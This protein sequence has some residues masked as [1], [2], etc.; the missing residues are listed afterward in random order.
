MPKQHFFF[1]YTQDFA[2]YR[3]QNLESKFLLSQT[4][5]Y[6]VHLYVFLVVFSLLKEVELDLSKLCGT[7]LFVCQANSKL[8][9]FK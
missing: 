9:P 3:N 4:F 8:S 2:L 6:N 7:S 1:H 5:S